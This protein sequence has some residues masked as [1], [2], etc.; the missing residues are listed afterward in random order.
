MVNRRECAMPSRVILLVAHDTGRLKARG[1]IRL[2]L[3]HAESIGMD[4]GLRL[5]L[6]WLQEMNAR[7]LPD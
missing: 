1:F 6:F 3:S 4:I 2:S 7:R 5:K